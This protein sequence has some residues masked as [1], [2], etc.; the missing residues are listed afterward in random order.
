M[1][2]T[3][4]CLNDEFC[5][6]YGDDAP[7]IEAT[8]Y[9]LMSRFIEDYSGGFYT[10][11]IDGNGFVLRFIDSDEKVNVVRTE[12]YSD[13]EM[14]MRDASMAVFLYTLNW[15]TW[16]TEGRYNEAYYRCRDMALDHANKPEDII[17]FLD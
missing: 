16:E 13:G 10:N 6:F 8:L 5:T 11:L 2:T 7:I 17:K 12:N 9:S 1:K 15:A 4:P 3:T 14:T